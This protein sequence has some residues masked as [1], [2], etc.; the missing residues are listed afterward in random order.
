LVRRALP[1]WVSSLVPAAVVVVAQQVLWPVSSGTFVSGLVIGALAALNAVGLA[2]IWRANRV[3]NIAQGDLGVL[4]AT[5]VLLMMEA[6]S[7]PYVAALPLGLAAAIV[8]GGLVELLVVR[9][10]AKASRLMLMVATIGISQG[11]TFAALL[12]PRAWGLIPSNRSYSPPWSMSVSIGEVVFHA[13]DVIA[14]IVAPVT[15]IGLVLFLKRSTVGIAIRASAE[16]SDRAGMLGIPVGR[17]QTVVWAIAGAL[18]FLS[19]FLTAGIT[20]LPAG[21]ATSLT[22]LLRSFTALVMGRMTNLATV[23]TSAVALGVLDAAIRANTSDTLVSPLL[24]LIILGV[25]L[26][27]RRR[28]TRADRDDVSSW[29]MTAEV[30]PVP[31][32]LSRLGAVR[33][34]RW[35]GGAV[36][37]GLVALLPNVVGTGT[38]LKAGAVLIFSAIG[39]SLV[40]LSGW[41]GQVSL[42]QMTFV[43]AGGAVAAWATVERGLD[44]LVALLAAGLVGAVVAVIVGLPALRLRGLYLAVTTLAL[45]LAASDAV[46]SNAYWDW[47]P[48][49][50][51]ARPKLLGRVSLDS[52]TRVYY[53]ALVVLLLTIVAVVGL[54]HSRIGRVLV[55]QRDNETAAAAY[56]ISV[57]RAK[58]CA[59][60]VSGFVAALAGATFVFHQASFRAES[61]DAGQSLIVFAATVTGGLGSVVG[62]VI[63]AVYARGAQ[64]LLSGNWQIL[65]SS[66]GVLAVLMVM[67]DGLS[68]I[69]FRIRD[70][71]LRWLAVRRGIDAPSLVRSAAPAPDPDPL[72]EAA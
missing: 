26:A 36:L 4:P 66:V 50:T 47:I 27:Q 17:L 21:P 46:F 67:P 23:A 55:A 25:L 63:G 2:L 18:S 58:L 51:F 68:G 54:R 14:A 6:W 62:A 52:A 20:A 16:R 39:I 70:A 13:N 1:P 22:I 65:A 28:A 7:L 32:A 69:A 53:L 30:R 60:A 5:L 61:Y 3:L 49:G 9:R 8:C 34:V 41:A 59:F 43:G 48:T 72:D 24:A 38:A 10:F 19:V 31:A 11:L 64:W 12:L 35:G 33:A 71:G 57:T 37:L 29:K 45:A 15:M 40:V 56:G 42:G 44:P